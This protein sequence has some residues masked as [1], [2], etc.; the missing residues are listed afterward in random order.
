MT[1][2]IAKLNDALKINGPVLLAFDVFNVNVNFPEGER[3]LHTEVFLTFYETAKSSTFQSN[4]SVA[5]AVLNSIV[6]DET[7]RFFLRISKVLLREKRKR[8]TMRMNR[9]FD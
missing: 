4:N 5:P 3:K 6:D 8:E 1:D 7:I 9:C 2:L